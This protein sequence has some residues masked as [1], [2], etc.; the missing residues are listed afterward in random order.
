MATI[1]VRGLDDAV[2]GALEVR[3]RANGRSMEAEARHVLEL[4]VGAANLTSG[5]GSRIHALFAEIG[6]LEL[7][8]SEHDP[9]ENRRREQPRAA[10]FD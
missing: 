5:L 6:G 4:S 8:G 2:K 3:A 10:T 7:D 1:T 9:V